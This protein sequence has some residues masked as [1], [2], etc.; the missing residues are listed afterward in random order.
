MISA[1]DRR[2]AVELIEQA[3]QAGARLAP[4]CEILGLSGRTV[5]R[6]TR[7]GGVGEDQRPTAIRP[8]P[9]KAL[10]PAEEQAI[11]EACHRP[12]FAHLP[13]GNCQDSC[14]LPRCHTA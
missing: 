2:R 6:W 5:Q 13:P 10:S 14:R 12:E 1:S 9:A 3:Q 8:K 4:A 11:L 7:H